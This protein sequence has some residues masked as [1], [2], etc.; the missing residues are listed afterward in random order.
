MSRCRTVRVFDD[1]VGRWTSFWISHWLIDDLGPVHSYSLF[2]TTPVSEF[3]GGVR[4]PKIEVLKIEQEPTFSLFLDD[5]EDRSPPFTLVKLYVCIAGQ[6][7]LFPNF[8]LVDG[9]GWVGFPSFYRWRSD[10]IR[11]L[12]VIFFRLFVNT[13][14]VGSL[15]TKC[16]SDPGLVPKYLV[17]DDRGVEW[18][19]SESR[20]Y[21]IVP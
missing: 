5:L 12:S 15:V 1:D 18:R 7:K 11:R 6:E 8:S 17:R 14:R 13:H 19:C 4:V 20:G 16:C 2:S 3:P 10:E 9:L 21:I